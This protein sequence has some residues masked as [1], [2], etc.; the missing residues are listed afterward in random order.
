[1]W[2]AG[3]PG[4]RCQK[5]LSINNPEQN[6]HLQ[7]YRG[8]ATVS[9][10]QV[11]CILYV[12]MQLLLPGQDAGI[13]LHDQLVRLAQSHPPRLNKAGGSSS[14]CTEFVAVEDREDQRCG[15]G[16]VFRLKN[17]AETAYSRDVECP[18]A[19]CSSQQT[20]VEQRWES[21][22]GRQRQG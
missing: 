3:I 11:V 21:G 8:G 4:H 18:G 2:L 19:L 15:N 6:Y 9:A 1:M 20:A 16:S 13:D 22:T 10:L 12:G 7:H 5:G 14:S 17:N